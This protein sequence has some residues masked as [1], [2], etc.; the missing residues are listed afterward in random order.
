MRFC[1]AIA[2]LSYS[3]CALALSVTFPSHSRG[4]ESLDRVSHVLIVYM[5]NHRFDNLFGE[6]PG[7]DG[8]AN[9]GAH[10]KQSD[11]KGKPYEYLPPAKDPF[12]GADNPTSLRAVEALVGLPNGPFRIDGV[13]PGVSIATVVRD[14]R[15]RFYTHRAQIHGGEMD[16]YAAW[17]DAGALVMGHYSKEALES[18]PLWRLAHKGVLMDHF[19]QGAFGG[20][21][22]NHFWLICGCSPAWPDAHDDLRSHLDENGAP[23]EG[24]KGDNIVTARPDDWAV[25]TVQSIFFNDG[26]QGEILLPGQNA[27]TIGDMLTAKGVDWRWYAGGWDLAITQKRNVEQ[28]DMLLNVFRFQWHHQ[29]FAYFE[30]FSPDTEKG[31]AERNLHLKGEAA[32]EEDIVNDKLPPVAFYKPTGNLNEH[33]GYA[34]IISGAEH[35]ERILHLLEQSPSKN[36]FAMIIVYDEYGGF[37]DHVPPPKASSVKWKADAFDPGSRIPAILISPLAPKD[38]VDSTQYD[39]TAVIKLIQD[40]FHLDHLPSCRVNAQSSMAKLFTSG[41]SPTHVG[42]LDVSEHQF[43][44]P[45]FCK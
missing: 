23:I 2:N 16:Q 24:P 31:R 12:T 27:P 35:I 26:K 11:K 42:E 30:R 38:V 9:L 28:D 34:G 29:P 3:I 41:A 15:H 25:N 40:C 5:E 22:L 18:T 6:Y 7:A 14:L 32:L 44:P 37:W 4:E 20:S 10:A 19:F 17:S 45:K 13:L 21:F 43:E 36:S 39:T 33:P 1:N 8:I